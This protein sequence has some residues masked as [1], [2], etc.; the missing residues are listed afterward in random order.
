[1]NIGQ[2]DSRIKVYQD[3]LITS[4]LNEE[5]PKPTLLKTIW[6][7]CAAANWITDDRTP[8]GHDAVK[9]D[10]Y[11]HCAGRNDI[12]YRNGLLFTVGGSKQTGAP[13]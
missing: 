8:C 13:V 9:N 6:G 7:Q 10:T 5:Q 4:E 1:M 3:T 2:L 11:H 12:R